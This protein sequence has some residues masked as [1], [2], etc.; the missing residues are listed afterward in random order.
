MIPCCVFTGEVAGTAAA[1]SI[2]KNC[3]P[4]RLSLK[5]LRSALAAKK[6]VFHID[7]LP[8]VSTQAATDVFSEE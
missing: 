4:S 3:R 5:Q 8:P 2:R 1:L 7:D 6:F